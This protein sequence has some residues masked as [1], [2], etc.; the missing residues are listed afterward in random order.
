MKI[1][2]NYE[3]I[4]FFDDLKDLHNRTIWDLPIKS[5]DKIDNILNAQ[6]F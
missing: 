1:S 4:C 3:I 5:I 6:N 2:K